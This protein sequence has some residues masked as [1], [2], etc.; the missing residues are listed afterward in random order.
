MVSCALCNSK[1]QPGSVFCWAHPAP[2]AP[3]IGGYSDD[4]GQL[5]W[6]SDPE[7]VNGVSEYAAAITIDGKQIEI[8]NVVVSI[9]PGSASMDFEIKSGGRGTNATKR[10]SVLLAKVVSAFFAGEE[11]IPATLSSEG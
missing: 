2:D 11:M 6:K 1:I 10:G 8:E 4:N 3:K 9:S 5:L 7:R